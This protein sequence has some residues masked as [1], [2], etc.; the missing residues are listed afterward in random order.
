MDGGS[1]GGRDGAMILALIMVLW[2]AVVYL[3]REIYLLKRAQQRQLMREWM[4]LNDK[5]WLSKER[6]SFGEGGM[7]EC[8]SQ[9]TSGAQKPKCCGICHS[10]LWDQA[11][12]R[13]IARHRPR[14][15]G[16]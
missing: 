12:G 9:L 7:L 8:M 14:S 6:D 10:R 15:A 1:E 3:W 13:E 11:R 2:A 5:L 4:R 16:Q